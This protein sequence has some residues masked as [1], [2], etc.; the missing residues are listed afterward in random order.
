MAL[1]KT[2]ELSGEGSILVDGGNIPTG[3][4]T[5]SMDCYIK[6]DN[7]SGNKD[8]VNMAVSFTELAKTFLKHYSFVPTLGNVNILEEGYKHLK[9]LPEFTGAT[10]V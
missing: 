5:I 7:V 4:Q 6:I 1:Q 2:F 9:T 10:D 8:K 3:T